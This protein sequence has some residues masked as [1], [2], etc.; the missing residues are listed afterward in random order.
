MALGVGHAILKAN[1]ITYPS[2]WDV[3][4]AT[5]LSF[6]IAFGRLRPIREKHASVKTYTSSTALNEPHAW[7]QSALSPKDG[8]T[9]T[10]FILVHFL[11]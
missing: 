6:Y 5:V 1:L 3:E 7:S 8:G 9:M 10:K 11:L 2:L 4:F